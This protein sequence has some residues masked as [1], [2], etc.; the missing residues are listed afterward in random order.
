MQWQCTMEN[1]ETQDMDNDSQDNVQ[2]K[3]IV[4]QLICKTECLRQAVED[5][6][7]DPRD[8]VH[9]LEQRLN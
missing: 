5:R 7:N 9:Q 6:D 2:D 3:N 4:Q 8:T 1:P